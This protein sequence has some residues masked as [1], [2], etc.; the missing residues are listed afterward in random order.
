[1]SS[2]S[3]LFFFNLLLLPTTDPIRLG[4]LGPHGYCPICGG[5]LYCYTVPYIAHY[6]TY[7]IQHCVQ[8]VKHID[9]IGLKT[10]SINVSGRLH[11]EILIGW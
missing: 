4:V 7:S 11:L 1:M 3:Q 9:L 2:K 5:E 6:M 8:Q 10:G